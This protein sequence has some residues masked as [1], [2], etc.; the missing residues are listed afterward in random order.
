MRVFN[1]MFAV[2]LV[3]SFSFLNWH[4]RSWTTGLGHAQRVAPMPRCCPHLAPT[5]HRAEVK[6]HVAL[7]HYLYRLH[8][9]SHSLALCLPLAM[10]EQGSSS[11]QPLLPPSSSNTGRIP[12]SPSCASPPSRA[13]GH[14]HC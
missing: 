13:F 6:S 1:H 14:R 5:C 7:P 2:V 11:Q 4:S 9:L 10:T 8:L 3:S 12:C